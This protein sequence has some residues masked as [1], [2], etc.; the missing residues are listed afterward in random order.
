MD[1]SDRR[2]TKNADEVDAYG[3]YR[4][5][6]RWPAGI[7]KLIKRRTHKR[8]RKEWKSENYDE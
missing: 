8:E 1:N 3:K 6:Y 7:R 4:N 2:R 5:I